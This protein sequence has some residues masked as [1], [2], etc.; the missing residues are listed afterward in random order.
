[1]HSFSAGRVAAD[2]LQNSGGLCLE[3]RPAEGGPD[4]DGASTVVCRRRDGGV[5][6]RRP[7]ATDPERADWDPFSCL[8]AALHDRGMT[9]TSSGR[10]IPPD[11]P[12]ASQRTAGRPGRILCR[13]CRHRSCKVLRAPGGP[14][15]RSGVNCG[16]APSTSSRSYPKQWEL[17][18]EHGE[19]VLRHRSYLQET[20]VI[21]TTDQP[22][23]GLPRLHPD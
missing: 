4:G 10:P 20:C 13:R 18:L 17:C 9:A 1:M 22:P 2:G 14:E 7:R 15:Q 8:P 3:L 11:G 12:L 5:V 19:V 23:S 16:D 21:A 6:A